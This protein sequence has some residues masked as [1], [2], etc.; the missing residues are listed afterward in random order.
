[1]VM[2]P[3]MVIIGFDPSPYGFIG[4]HPLVV[5]LGGTSSDFGCQSVT[6][7]ETCRPQVAILKDEVTRGYCRTSV[8]GSD[9]ASDLKILKRN[10]KKTR[11][12]SGYV[13]GFWW[14]YLW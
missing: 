4:F 2:P 9:V 14:I 7:T 6:P 10:H 13:Q 12:S 11:D 5:F 3:K 1:M 8:R